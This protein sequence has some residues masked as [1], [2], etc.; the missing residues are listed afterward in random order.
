MN[1]NE[2][3]TTEI[4]KEYREL[5]SSMEKWDIKSLL[6][7]YIARKKEKENE[8]DIFVNIIENI[9]TKNI[10]KAN[11]ERENGNDIF[12]SYDQ[13]LF[14]LI[15]IKNREHDDHIP[16]GFDNLDK[17]LNGGVEKGTTFLGAIS[18]LGK[19]TFM[20]NVAFNMAENGIKVLFFSLEMSREKV[21]EKIL[22]M[23]MF[24]KYNVSVSSTQIHNWYTVTHT[25]E[26][27]DAFN[28]AVE[29][30]REH[31][32]CNLFI[33]TN[34]MH[35]KVNLTENRITS[36]DI[37]KYYLKFMNRCSVNDKVVIIV[38]YLHILQQD[39]N[40]KLTDKQNVEKSVNELVCLADD[41]DIPIIVISS[42][43]RDN[44]KE[45]ANMSAFKE[46]GLIEYSADCA[47][48]LQYADMFNDDSS[49]SKDF[50]I[51][52]AQSEETRK[53]QA[54]ILKNRY[55]LVGSKA[56]SDFEFVP[57]CSA[58]KEVNGFFREADEKTKKVFKK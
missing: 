56:V 40:L 53:V 3:T 13:F 57:K 18:S 46:S 23:I 6:E 43:N 22:S 49:A 10:Q 30:M 37:K 42:F 14:D 29:Y 51:R 31:I 55:G 38:D 21:N 15:N 44:Y 45:F 19:S 52:K 4:F 17:L 39:Y 9:L 34:K 8:N 25:K 32:L 26:E 5:Y 50:D 1:N 24:K 2:T 33:I 58:F 35:K 12:D 41:Y 27:V 54:V 20:L 7:V 28:N 48:A 36:D 47:I 11:E 16:T